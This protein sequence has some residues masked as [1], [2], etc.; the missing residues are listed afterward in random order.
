MINDEYPFEQPTLR[1]QIRLVKDVYGDFI[2]HS[3]LNVGE[4]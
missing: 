2:E 1:L 4:P 3:V